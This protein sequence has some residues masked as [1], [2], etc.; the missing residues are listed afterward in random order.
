L[1][2]TRND[3]YWPINALGLTAV[4]IAQYLLV[5]MIVNARNWSQNAANCLP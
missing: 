2:P 4:L 5:A 3:I 1:L